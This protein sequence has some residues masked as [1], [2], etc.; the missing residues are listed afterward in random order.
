MM[1]LGEHLAEGISKSISSMYNVTQF[2][3]ALYNVNRLVPHVQIAVIWVP[4][5][6]TVMYIV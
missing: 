1:K 5:Y 4:E 6:V 3:V 2:V